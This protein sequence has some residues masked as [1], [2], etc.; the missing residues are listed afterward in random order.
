VHAPV[1]SGDCLTC[2]SGHGS[3]E[4]ALLSHKVADL[5]TGCHDA[6]APPLVKAH[7]GLVPT[8]AGC[9]SCHDPHVSPRKGLVRAVGH[10]PFTNEDCGG[11]H[12]ARGAAIQLA[13]VA[14]PTELCLVCHS[15]V[16]RE[17]GRTFAHAPARDGECASCHSPHASANERLLVKT[18]AALCADC[19]DAD[20]AKKK[21]VHTPVREGKCLDCHGPH[22]SKEDKGLAKAGNALCLSCHQEVGKLL[23]AKVVHQPVGQGQCRTCHDAHATDHP[24]QLVAAPAQLCRRC[25]DPAK[26]ALRQAHQG[27]SLARLGCITCH[28]PHG[29]PEQGLIRA[30]PHKVFRACDKCHTSGG[31]KAGALLQ[32][33]PALCFRCHSEKRVAL[34]KPGAHEGAKGDCLVCHAAHAASQKGLPGGDERATCL[35]C[36]DEVQRTLG[37]A[38]SI[39][40]LKAERGRC[41][42]CHE[43]HQTANRKL[44]RRPEQDLCRTCHTGHAQF[45]HPIG[46]NVLDPR[47]GQPLSCLSCHGPHGTQWGSI[48]L[49]NPSQ[50]LCV[51]CHDPSGA[52]GGGKIGP[53]LRPGR[54]R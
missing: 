14:K 8:G 46:S 15:T 53:K 10:P 50:A 26:P 47:T 40:P 19:H 37:A 21:S 28:D 2:H 29:S 42:A 25:H 33:T 9:V 36:H 3:G 48:L 49:D 7:R 13:L 27:F 20:F 6:K 4:P 34:G 38:R 35:G 18:G 23:K 41:S 52:M 16:G 11:C 43:P 24:A 54:A 44:L 5:C 22:S 51:R 45:G 30:A 39:H 12:Q 31:P 17:P 1:V 32:A